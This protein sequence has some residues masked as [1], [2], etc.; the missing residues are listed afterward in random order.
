MPLEINS[1]N[2]VKCPITPFYSPLKGLIKLS[3][4]IQRIY[5][6]CPDLFQ[7]VTSSPNSEVL[8]FILASFKT[9]ILRLERWLSG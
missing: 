3:L 7:I 9:L 6:V 1:K 5:L 8:S 4:G 2:T